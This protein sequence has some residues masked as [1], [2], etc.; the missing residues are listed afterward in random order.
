M[1]MPGF[2]DGPSTYGLQHLRALV[3]MFTIGDFI[4]F[5]E[6]VE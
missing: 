3:G 6:R 5:T 2:L 1:Y 4:T